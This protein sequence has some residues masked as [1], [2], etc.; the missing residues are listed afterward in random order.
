MQALSQLSYGPTMLRAGNDSDLKQD[1]EEVRIHFFHA[2]TRQRSDR[3][4]RCVVSRTGCGA[5]LCR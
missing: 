3:P 1:W 4:T 2:V 5:S